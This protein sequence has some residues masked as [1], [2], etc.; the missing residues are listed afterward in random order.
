MKIEHK[1]RDTVINIISVAILIIA[2][3]V[4]LIFWKD[5]PE[6]VVTHYGFKGQADSY[7]SKNSLLFYP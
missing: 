4:L 1:K 3:L 7:G 6:T 2:T 5:I